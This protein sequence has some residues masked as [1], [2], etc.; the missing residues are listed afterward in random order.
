MPDA[1]KTACFK[2]SAYWD[3]EGRAACNLKENQEIKTVVSKMFLFAFVFI[4]KKKDLICRCLR[5]V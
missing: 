2:I 3:Y 5:E 4:A 1:A